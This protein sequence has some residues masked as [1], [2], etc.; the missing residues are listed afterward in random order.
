MT[1]SPTS[2]P[3][4]ADEDKDDDDYHPQ[5]QIDNVIIKQEAEDA[6]QLPP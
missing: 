3:S 2:P 4:E 5:E 6:S 1:A